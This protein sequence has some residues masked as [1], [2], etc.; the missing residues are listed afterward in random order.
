MKVKQNRSRKKNIAAQKKNKQ[1]YTKLQ[2]N[3]QQPNNAKKKWQTHT[4]QGKRGWNKK[5]HI[6]I[7]IYNYIH[8]YMRM[9]VR[10]ALQQSLYN[11]NLYR[12]SPSSA[13]WRLLIKLLGLQKFSNNTTGRSAGSGGRARAKAAS[14]LRQPP[15]IN[16]YSW[17]QIHTNTNTNTNNIYIYIHTI[18]KKYLQH[19]N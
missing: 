12:N 8:I 3:I 14:S 16:T 17:T 6:Y 4:K 18:W 10:H 9:H 2:T 19:A 7:Y 11:N 5:K 1:K 15:G 13:V